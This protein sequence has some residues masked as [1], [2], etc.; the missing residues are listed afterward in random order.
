MSAA[1][2]TTYRIVRKELC[3]STIIIYYKHP[4][5]EQ[6][7]LL[8]GFGSEW[9]SK[10]SL[11]NTFTNTNNT[12]NID[13]RK[14]AFIRNSLPKGQQYVFTK[15]RERY[16][17][18]IKKRGKSSLG[19]VKGECEIG[20]TV[21]EAIRREIKEEIGYM[22][23]DEQIKP[24]IKRDMAQCIVQNSHV[25]TYEV[26]D[27]DEKRAI[28][29]AIK[30]L[31]NMREGELF[32]TQFYRHQDIEIRIR[33]KELNPRSDGAYRCFKDIIINPLPSKN[34]SNN[35]RK[36]RK[37]RRTYSRHNNHN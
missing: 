32:D 22:P 5:S 30:S 27:L 31:H 12:Y 19:F 28:E 14:R 25:F 7:E 16:I 15:S 34:T 20:E 8:V 29:E 6:Y 13:E 3:H 26:R 10:V 33:R 21:E 17:P 9:D 2:R 23:N 11:P 1:R 36:T 37:R 18:L 24:L 4:D 35:T